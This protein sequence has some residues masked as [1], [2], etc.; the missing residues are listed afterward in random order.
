ML[1]GS[2]EN[3]HEREGIPNRHRFAQHTCEP[4]RYLNVSAIS[5]LTQLRMNEGGHGEFIT[6]HQSRDGCSRYVVGDGHGNSMRREAG[7]CSAIAVRV[8]K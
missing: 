6:Y 1:E 8:V 2:T 4:G 5:K 3:E 7:R